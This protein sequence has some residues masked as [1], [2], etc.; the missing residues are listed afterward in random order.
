MKKVLNKEN[1]ETYLWSLAKFQNRYYIIK[2]LLDRYF[3]SNVIS[4]LSQEEDPF[5]DPMEPTIIG[6]GFY[7]LA[8]L[9]YLF[10]DPTE[11][12]LVGDFQGA[13]LHVPAI[14]F[15]FFNNFCWLI[16]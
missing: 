11:I 10:D 1:G 4:T 6:Q 12:P 14:F 5:W 13:S 2:D 9:T 16:I 8:S 15:F 7:K 3:E